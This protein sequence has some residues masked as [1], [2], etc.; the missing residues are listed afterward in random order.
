MRDTEKIVRIEPYCEGFARV[1]LDYGM[2]AFVDEK[3]KCY[4]RRW[5]VCVYR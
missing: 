1:V 2:Y 3:G 5:Q 4:V